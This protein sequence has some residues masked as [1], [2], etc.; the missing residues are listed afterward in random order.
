MNLVHVVSLNAQEVQMDTGKKIY[1]PRGSYQPLRK[2]YFEYY[3]GDSEV[4]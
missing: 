2:R 3:F 4:L 1:L